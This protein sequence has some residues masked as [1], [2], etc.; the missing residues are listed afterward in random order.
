M[1]GVVFWFLHLIVGPQKLVLLLFVTSW[2]GRVPLHYT[3]V[4]WIL[5]STE[6]KQ[7]TY[8]YRSSYCVSPEG[9]L[10]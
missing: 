2:L 8:H 5:P 9:K 1:L 4:S 10:F 7:G 3:C 6:E